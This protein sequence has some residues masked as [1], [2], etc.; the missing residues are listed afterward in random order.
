MNS[1]N[2]YELF[3]IYLSL[4]M[5]CILAKKLTSVNMYIWYIFL[6]FSK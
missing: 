5:F 1:I 4:D 6:L 3:I 2:S